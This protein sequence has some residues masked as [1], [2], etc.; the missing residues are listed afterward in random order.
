METIVCIRRGCQ[1]RLDIRVCE[2][3]CPT[4]TKKRC[5]NWQLRLRKIALQAQNPQPETKQEKAS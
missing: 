1:P 3:K 2:S 5:A 4:R